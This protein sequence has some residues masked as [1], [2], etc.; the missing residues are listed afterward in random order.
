MIAK[1]AR[2]QPRCRSVSSLRSRPGSCFIHALSAIPA[3]K[4][5][6]QHHQAA[7]CHS[8]RWSGHGRPGP[9][10]NRK[11]RLFFAG[12]LPGHGPSKTTTRRHRHTWPARRPLGEHQGP[13]RQNC[14]CQT[15]SHVHD[16]LL[17]GFHLKT[18]KYLVMDE[19]KSCMASSGSGIGLVWL[20]MLSFNMIPPQSLRA[21]CLCCRL[22]ALNQLQF[23]S[24]PA[25]KDGNLDKQAPQNGTRHQQAQD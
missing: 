23:R 16:R 9:R 18:I 11:D 2:F 5:H 20:S 17:Q 12:T 3:D 15:A 22:S 13:H 10:Q 8:G 19:A 21:F 6:R 25:P 4:G 1:L 14:R 7:D 24:T